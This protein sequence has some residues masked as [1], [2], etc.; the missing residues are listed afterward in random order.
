[1]DE[2]FENSLY[3]RIYSS[4][5]ETFPEFIID[6]HDISRYFLDDEKPHLN[7]RC[8]GNILIDHP[9]DYLRKKHVDFSEREAMTKLLLENLNKVKGH[10]L[11]RFDLH[12]SHETEQIKNGWGNCD[13]FY[14]HLR[15]DITVGERRLVDVIDGESLLVKKTPLLDVVFVGINRFSQRHL[16]ERVTWKQKQDYF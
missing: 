9:Y 13:E 12:P 11:T 6:K 8:Y 4:L 1:M 3:H 15:Y 7:V 2:D 14:E 16:D 10:I 5:R